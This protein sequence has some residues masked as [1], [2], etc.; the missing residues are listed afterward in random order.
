M[1]YRSLGPYDDQGSRIGVNNDAILD[2]DLP[3]DLNGCDFSVRTPLVG[4]NNRQWPQKNIPIDL[5]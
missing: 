1:G 5:A 4:P 3:T 2:I